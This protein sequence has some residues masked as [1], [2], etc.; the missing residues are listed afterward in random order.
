[1]T[2]TFD[3]IGRAVADMGKALSFC[4]RP[5]LSFPAGSDAQPHVGSV[6]L[7]AAAPG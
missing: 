3:A 1:M 5:G 6:D 4:R 7:F 2:P